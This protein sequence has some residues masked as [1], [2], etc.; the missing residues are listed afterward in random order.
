MTTSSRAF[1]PRVSSLVNGVTKLSKLPWAG[2]VDHSKREKE[3]QAES[4]RKMFLAMVDDIGVVL[5][6]LADR[7]H[8]MRTLQFMP[9]EK[10]QSHRAADDGD[11]RAAGEPPGNLAVQE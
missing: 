1:G 10:Q 2:D 4:L 8:N 5:I 9:P 11:L 6:K 3:A 7:L